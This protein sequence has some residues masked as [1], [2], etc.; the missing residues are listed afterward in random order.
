MEKVEKCSR[1]FL[2]GH[3][4]SFWLLSALLSQLKQD[5]FTPLDPALFD[6]TI[7]SLSSTLPSQMSLAVGLADFVASKRRESY[8]AHVSLLLSAPQKR[9]LIVTPGSETALF[10]QSLLKKVSGQVKEDSFVSFLGQVW[11]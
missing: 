4:H 7:L 1:S 10:N 5:G 11:G 3:S 2:E 8:L 6:K 9:E